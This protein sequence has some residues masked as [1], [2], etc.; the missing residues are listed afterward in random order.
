MPKAE[1]KQVSHPKGP[2]DKKREDSDPS[3]A[4]IKKRLRDTMR[5]LKRPNL[6]AI[7]KT[8]LERRVKALELELQQLEKNSEAQKLKQKYKYVKFVERK[9]LERKMHQLEHSLSTQNDSKEA[10]QKGQP[11]N[12]EKIQQE[13]QDIKSK[14]MYIDHYPKDLKYISLMV[15]ETMS[16][17]ASQ[18]QRA[19]LAFMEKCLLEKKSIEKE[20]GFKDMTGSNP[21]GESSSLAEEGPKETPQDASEQEGGD[22]DFFL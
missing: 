15:T 17:D 7:V 3:P 2:K 22:D 5:T 14:L 21:T 9:K 10:D 16:Q 18:K 19:I 4:I 8:D 11:M 6:S 1:R 13:I 12:P 20:L